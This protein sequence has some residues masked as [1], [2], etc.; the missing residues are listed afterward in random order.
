[1]DVRTALAVQDI[2]GL[3]KLAVRSLGA[4]ALGLGITAVLGGSHALL[5]SEKL[6][7]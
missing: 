5:V 1:M 2:A 7:I 3:D 4:K 6:Q